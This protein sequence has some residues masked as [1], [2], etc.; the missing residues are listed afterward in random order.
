AIIDAVRHQHTQV[1]LRGPDDPFVDAKLRKRDGT[2]ADIG[3]DIDGI[4]RVELP[5]HVAG[6]TTMFLELWRNGAK[7]QEVPVTSDDFSAVLTD[8]PGPGDVRYRVELTNAGARRI[9]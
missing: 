1:L 5:V 2:L 9:V 8:E 7:V 3:D 6:A 4:S